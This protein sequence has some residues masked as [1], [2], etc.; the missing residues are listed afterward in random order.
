LLSRLYPGMSRP[1]NRV[2]RNSEHRPPLLHDRFPALCD[3]LPHLALGVAPT[4][5]RPLA[6]VDRDP[7]AAPI[8]LKHDGLYGTIRG[9]NKVR[10]LEWTLPEVLARGRSTILTFGALGTNHGLTTAL[11]G[12]EH[13]LRTVLA[14]V[15]QPLDDHVRRQFEA[16]ERSGARLY[17]T[18]GKYR[19]IAALPWLLARNFDRAAR[20]PPYFL[21]PG[22]SSPLG[23]I[24]YVEAAFELAEQV[25]S[26]ELPEPSHAVVALGS[27][28][29][30]AGLLLGLQ[31]AGLRTRVVAVVVNDTIKLTPRFV[32]RL[33]R[34]A[35]RLLRARGADLPE[36]SL[37]EAD[38]D[39]HRRWLGPGYGHST[40][41]GEGAI[42]RLRGH[43]P[44]LEPVYTAKA[45]AALLELRAEGAFGEGPVLYW[46]TH[47]ALMPHDSGRA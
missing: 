43:G 29:T 19:T 40:A 34:R 1:E 18:R 37:T 4:P 38:V 12:R 30:A 28:G 13:G 17:R 21:P 33:A 6:E 10:K 5:V 2:L 14:L 42:A 11:Y 16:I 36:L 31:L 23:C 25:R 27:G 32:T 47:D 41:E 7:G 15:D 26:G 8:W 35:A 22:G 46:H 20:R 3:A 44:E 45:M 24:G 39:V 9:G